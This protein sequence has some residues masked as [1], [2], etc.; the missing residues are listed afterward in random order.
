MVQNGS[1]GK[2]E[3]NHTV[4]SNPRIEQ[5]EDLSV[6]GVKGR[7]PGLVLWP[8]INLLKHPSREE[9]TKEKKNCVLNKY[10]FTVVTTP[11]HVFHVF[12]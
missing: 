12:A 6:F 8:C 11:V 5:F 1:A 4:A 3:W 7:K 9:E 10:I 2:C